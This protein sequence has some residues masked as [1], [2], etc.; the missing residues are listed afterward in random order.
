M[1]PYNTFAGLFGETSV[2]LKY[3]QEDIHSSLIAIITVIVYLI[4]N[5][6]RLCLDM[7]KIG[8]DSGNYR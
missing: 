6:T 3:G 2:Q 1:N 4:A 5:D 8:D 7:F